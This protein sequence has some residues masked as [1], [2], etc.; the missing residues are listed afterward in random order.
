LG[1]CRA[2]DAAEG[3]AELLPLF[4]GGV[5]EEAVEAADCDEAAAELGEGYHAADV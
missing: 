1:L 2:S 5:A 4:W 3:E